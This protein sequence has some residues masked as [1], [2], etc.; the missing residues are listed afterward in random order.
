MLLALTLQTLAAPPDPIPI[1]DER[2]PRPSHTA[3]VVGNAVGLGLIVGGSTGVVLGS[4][5]NSF[6]CLQ[7][8]AGLFGVAP[9]TGGTMVVSYMTAFRA[10]A[11][12]GVSDPRRGVLGWVGAGLVTGG[13]GFVALSFAGS[14]APLRG[15]FGP[16][17]VMVGSGLPLAIAQG[18][19]NARTRRE[20]DRQRWPMS[21]NLGLVEQKPGLVVTGTW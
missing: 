12:H 5:C 13:I 21:V 4:G 6:A 2:P 10:H 20:R 9:I 19:R 1:V 15:L 8:W 3:T 7:I 11:L 14:G 16:G 18:A 17:M